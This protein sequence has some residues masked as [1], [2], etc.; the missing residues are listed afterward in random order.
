MKNLLFK[1]NNS[2]SLIKKFEEEI[3]SKE[4]IFDILNG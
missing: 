4:T 3:I 2:K 1:A